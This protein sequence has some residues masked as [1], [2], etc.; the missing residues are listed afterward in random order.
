MRNKKSF[1]A[2]VIFGNLFAV[3][4]FIYLNYYQE[5]WFD[6]SQHPKIEI[7]NITKIEIDDGAWKWIDKEWE[8]SNDTK[9]IITDKIKIKKFCQA[10]ST[11]TSK[12]IDNIRPNNWLEIHFYYNNKKEERVVVLNENEDEGVFFEYDN[13]TFEG[14]LLSEIIYSLSNE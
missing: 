12:Y 13:T 2:L 4:Y 8:R 3:L 1:I 10:M 7:E 5:K 11:S 6:T 14:K 9:L